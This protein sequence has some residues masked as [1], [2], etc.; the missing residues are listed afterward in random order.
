MSEAQS[1][2]RYEFNNI[3]YLALSFCREPIKIECAGSS[4]KTYRNET[5]A[6]I[7]DAILDLVIVERG[8]ADGK[9]KKQIDDMRQKN[10]KNERLVSFLKEKD[11]QQFCYKAKYFY[12][13]APGNDRV[14][15]G[16]HDAIVEAI[17]GAIYLDGDGDLE[18]V[19]DWITNNI[20]T[21]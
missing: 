7:G 21:Q 16:K 2:I 18:K 3:S 12:N 14:S 8:F 5:L 11:L 17:I 20:L 4:N 13:D 19:R 9:N 6:Q 10:A 15:S 1:K